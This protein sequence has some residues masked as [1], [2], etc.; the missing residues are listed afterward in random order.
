MNTVPSFI[1]IGE[2]GAINNK[3]EQWPSDA[4]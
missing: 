4:I 1:P 2:Y 3:L